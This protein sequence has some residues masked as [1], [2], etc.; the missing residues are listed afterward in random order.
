[1][2]PVLPI[3]AD[4]ADLERALSRDECALAIDRSWAHEVGGTVT[5]PTVAAET[6]EMKAREKEGKRVEDGRDE[7]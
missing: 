6:R 1:M 5:W 4:R 7:K 2:S 3:T